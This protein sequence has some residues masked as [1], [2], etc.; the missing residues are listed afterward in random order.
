MRAFDLAYRVA[1]RAYQWA[2]GRRR[3]HSTKAAPHRLLA[4]IATRLPGRSGAEYRALLALASGALKFRER[5]HAGRRN[6]GYEIGGAVDA[7]ALREL[8]R[9]Q[10]AIVA[11][12]GEGS[13][14][15][16]VHVRGDREAVQLDRVNALLLMSEAVG[17]INFFFDDASALDARTTAL[18]LAEE[19]HGWGVRENERALDYALSRTFFENPAWSRIFSLR[20]GFDRGVNQYLKIAHPGA[21]VVAVSLPEDAAGFADAA[22]P[23]WLD[24]IA[25]VAR[26][27]RV[28]FVFLNRFSDTCDACSRD[29]IAF[30]GEA[31]LGFAQ[32]LLLARK[33][34]AYIGPVD[35]FGLAARVA[36]RPG[37]Y[38]GDASIDAAD[39]ARGIVQTPELDP[40]I[41]VAHVVRAVGRAEDGPL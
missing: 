13:F 15:V 38:A 28:R 17:S 6:F 37:V 23:A 29:S 21:H 3:Y 1:V 30:A 24:A 33:A 4:R 10:Y 41:A 27:T 7:H 40:R 5:L 9:W 19:R 36:R 35:I 22:L 12:H 31:G 25:A 39:E 34:D 32:A 2:K 26:D 11:A 18:T 20:T 8:A 16:N 14:H